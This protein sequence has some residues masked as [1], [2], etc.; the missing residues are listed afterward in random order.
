MVVMPNVIDLPDDIEITLDEACR[1]FFRGAITPASLR[2]EAKRGMLAIIR[3]GNKDFVTPA[4]IR[5]MRQKKTCQESDSHQ[6]SISERTRASGSSEMERSQSARAAA[7]ATA[8]QLKRLSRT[9]SRKS[10]SQQSA[11][12]VQLS[13][14]SMRS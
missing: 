12:I 2:A 13:S 4:A 3:V 9:T 6:G 14:P 1:I 8:E 10:S 11:N 5:E 7:L